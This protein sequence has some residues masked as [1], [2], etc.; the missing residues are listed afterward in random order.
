MK[1]AAS[2]AGCN[3]AACRSRLLL[4][5]RKEAE[6][7]PPTSGS[8]SS[9]M[10]YTNT[11]ADLTTSRAKAARLAEHVPRRK[12]SR[13]ALPKRPRL[14]SPAQG[15]T[16]GDEHTNADH[17]PRCATA[18]APQPSSTRSPKSSRSLPLLPSTR[19]CENRSATSKAC[20][21]ELP[22]KRLGQI[23]ARFVFHVGAV[24][25]YAGGEESA[26]V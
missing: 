12:R 24:V 3:F 18:A 16:P 13:R 15:T 8:S 21:A 25:P 14:S 10:K 9:P 22:E 26:I 2:L 17:P 4:L 11:A 20:Y 6:A 7:R 1:R 23:F 19:K 5:H